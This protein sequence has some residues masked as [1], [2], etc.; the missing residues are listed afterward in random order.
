MDMR[1]TLIVVVFCILL[2][3]SFAGIVAKL[4]NGKEISLYETVYAL[5]IGNGDYSNGWNDL[6]NAVKD[7]GEVAMKFRQFGF[8][9]TDKYNL[10]SAEMNKA[11]SEFV[12]TQG[13]DENS[14]LLV[15]Y[16]GHG[17][18]EISADGE[19]LGYIIPVDTPLQQQNPLLFSDKAISMMKIEEYSLKI[20]S[21]HVLMLFDSCFSGSIFDLGRNPV[22]PVIDEKAQAKVRQ[23]ITSGSEDESVPDKSYFKTCFLQ[24]LDGYADLNRDG[25]VTGQELGSYLSDQVV[26]YTNRAQHPQ[27]GKI[28]NPNLDKGDFV[29][30]L[31]QSSGALTN[32]T[33]PSNKEADQEVETE[34][35][36]G[37]IR[38]ESSIAGD[39]YL[40]KK[41]ICSIGQGEIKTIKRTPTGIHDVELRSPKETQSKRINVYQ[42]QL[43]E[44]R[45][46]PD[47]SAQGMVYVEGSSFMMGDD[48][49][50]GDPDE[51]PLHKVNISSFYIGKY[52]LTQKIFK[53]IMGYNTSYFMNPDAPVEM[54]SWYECID[55]CNKL[56]KKEDL[57]PVY[58]I[59]QSVKDPGNM[60]P[61]DD[62]KWQVIYEPRANGYR[63][64]TEAEW[65]YAARGGKLSRST[66]Y[67]GSSNPWT[68]GW[69]NDPDSDE[70][71]WETQPVGAKQA[72]ELGL[73]DMSGNVYEWCW[74]WYGD[75]PSTELHNP[76]GPASG[77]YRVIRGGSFYSES[78]R[79]RLSLRGY[80][81]PNRYFSLIGMRLAR[82]VGGN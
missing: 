17:D 39:I 81:R 11:I 13:K 5:V 6:P 42:D 61:E 41:L 14:A 72:N 55:L 36:T 74:D 63:L 67:A 10:N 23:Y 19:K 9:V 47:L 76:D 75:Y 22:P 52:E 69:Y 7:A 8:N 58:T 2:V 31:G 80:D 29:F 18:T 48:F 45:F 34:Y 60:Q 49:G 59:I 3:P 25:Y 62:I 37:S 71:L 53:E 51:K 79:L 44:L 77:N 26:N 28:R 50:V 64:P 16:A 57:E 46:I 38:I 73:F 40:D 30:V 35:R 4:P 21:R 24:G 32:S 54:V 66:Q 20:K 27:F 70:W 68:I 12:Y 43:S 82:S 33:S 65:E 15:Y 1:N 78:M 56:S